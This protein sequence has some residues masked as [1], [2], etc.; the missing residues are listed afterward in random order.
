MA[1]K[2][3]AAEDF[4]TNTEPEEVSANSFTIPKGYTLKPLPKSERLQC[5]VTKDLKDSLKAISTRRGIS[6]NALIN[7]ILEDY[8]SSN[9]D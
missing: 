2:F 5:L 4:L 7:L 8:V 9:M 3:N 1:K 6:V